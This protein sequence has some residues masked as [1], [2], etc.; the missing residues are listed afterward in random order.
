MF[1][2]L[3]VL[4]VWS[5]FAGAAESQQWKTR[6]NMLIKM[7]ATQRVNMTKTMRKSRSQRR[8]GYTR[9][10]FVFIGVTVV[11]RAGQE[12]AHAS[13]EDD[14]SKEEASSEAS[15]DQR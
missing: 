10:E 14:S 3:N 5:E 4:S 13:K 11:C 6:K 1:P 7:K 15:K 2:I 8:Q 12:E 9:F